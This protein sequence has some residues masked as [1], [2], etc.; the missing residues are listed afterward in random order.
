M[1]SNLV[2][3]G[4]AAKAVAELTGQ[5]PDTTTVWRWARHGLRARTGELVH[6]AHV[7]CGSRLLIKAEGI[8]EFFERLTAADSEYFTRK[9]AEREAARKSERDAA[10]ARPQKRT[11][12]QRE[13]DLAAARKVLAS[14]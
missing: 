7:R 8:A 12:K 6:L 5:R 4:A 10:K 13:R 2:S 3:L 9:V 1:Q 11:P 14:A